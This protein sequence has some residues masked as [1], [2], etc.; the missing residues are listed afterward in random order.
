MMIDKTRM[1][2]GEKNV[3]RTQALFYELQ[4]DLSKAL[5]TMSDDDKVIDGVHL[6]S[7]KRLY[8]EMEDLGEHTFAST[9]LMG[10]KHWKQMQGN[11][12]I[13]E[14]IEEW[15]DE[16]EAKMRSRGIETMV[17]VAAGKGPS[18]ST[19]AKWL[20]DGGW[21]PKKV[22]RPSEKA[23]QRDE[24]VQ[25]DMRAFTADIVRIGDT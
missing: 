15:R 10:W 12:R 22:G 19:A 23:K 14:E 25:S 1:V 17:G 3:P 7:L 21:K 11:K 9:Y 4:W 5:F 8:M 20:V 6:Y 24:K 18:A 13:M 2:A 16:L